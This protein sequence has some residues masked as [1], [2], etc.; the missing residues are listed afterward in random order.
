MSWIN[1]SPPVRQIQS[2]GQAR[3]FRFRLER[4]PAAVI[5]RPPRQA[6]FVSQNEQRRLH[7]ERRTKRVGRPSRKPSP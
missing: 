1:G 4:R 6:D 7:P 3:R 2:V 5:V